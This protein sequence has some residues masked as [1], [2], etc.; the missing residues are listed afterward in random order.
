VFSVSTNPAYAH[1]GDAGVVSTGLDYSS[2]TW[3]PEESISSTVG[4]IHF[5]NIPVKSS[6]TIMG[7]RV[8]TSFTTAETGAYI[9]PMGAGQ[10]YATRFLGN[11]M[12]CDTGDN[13]SWSEK[14]LVAGVLPAYTWLVWHF[15]TDFDTG[16][17]WISWTINDIRT[18]YSL[19]TNRCFTI[20]TD[21]DHITFT[22]R[23]TNHAFDNIN[24]LGVCGPGNCDLCETF[25]ECRDV[26]CYWHYDLY[27]NY[28]YCAEYPTGEC[29]AGPHWIKCQ[30]CLSQETCEAVEDCYWQYGYCRF[31]FGECAGGLQC[32]FCAYQE[33]CEAQGCYWYNNFCWISEPATTTS[34]VDYYTEYGDYPTS[35]AFVNQMASTTGVIFGS[36][37]SFL[38]GF[39]E[40]FDSQEALAYGQGFGSAV[41]KARGYLAI[42]NEFFGELPVA[43]IFLFLISFL[44]AVGLFRLI[45]NLITLFKFW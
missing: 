5:L 27:E 20:G 6:A 19:D 39:V 16:R 10:P 12:N 21:F 13:P 23:K 26:G 28:F 4:G 42:F 15:K 11:M 3:T 37:N 7:A 36:I 33:T 44:L 32:Q 8:Y 34:W 45:R 18:D 29:G 40:A 22:T 2:I 14:T 30:P 38:S 24:N 41:P 17:T 25:N 43:Q 1:E 31:S 35:S 9:T